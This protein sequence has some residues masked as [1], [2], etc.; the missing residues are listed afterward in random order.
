M[1]TVFYDIETIPLALEKR[2]HLRPS[3]ESVKLGNL[4]DPVKVAA[5]QNEALAAWDAGEG[6]ALDPMQCEIALLGFCIDDGGYNHLTNGGDDEDLLLHEFW[7]MVAKPSNVL[8][9]AHN[10]RFD[11]GMIVRRSWLNE[12]TVP[13]KVLNDI[14]SFSPNQWADTMQVWGAGDRQTT[15]MSLDKLAKDFGVIVKDSEV[16]GKEFYKWWEK[17]RDACIEYNRQDV[18]ATRDVWYA[19]GGI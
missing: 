19:M 11:L 3:A 17:D 13:P 1:S 2:E 7:D 9:V 14:N 8:F 15:Y 6:A 12:I 16:T 5:K 10:F 4:K 18:E